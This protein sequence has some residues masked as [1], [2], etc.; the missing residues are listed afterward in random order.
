MKLREDAVVF[1]ATGF[2]IGK[3]PFAPGS[4][5]SLIGLPLAW[6]LAGI[7]LGLAIL[8]MLLFT[9]FSVCVADAAEKILKQN[10][11]GC[12]VI[13]EI[14]GMMVSLTGLPHTPITIAL[15]FIVFRILDI[16]KPFPIRHLDKRIPGGLGVVADDVAAGI[17]TNL[18]LRGLLIFL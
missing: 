15:G 11:P 14:V 2:Y 12:I 1:L 3:I 10:D 7:P 8:C 9:I 16:I 6:V 13:D 4:F 17:I 5:G 18:L